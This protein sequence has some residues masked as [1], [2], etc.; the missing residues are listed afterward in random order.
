MAGQQNYS[1][2]FTLVGP[3]TDFRNN[4]YH[5]CGGQI[6]VVTAKEEKLLRHTQ[7]LRHVPSVLK[8]VSSQAQ[9]VS[10]FY[11]AKQR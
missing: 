10:H 6:I 8:K 2:G 7:N 5:V 11:I 3:T 1:A 9:V 4:P